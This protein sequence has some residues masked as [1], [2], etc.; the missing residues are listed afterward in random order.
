VGACYVEYYQQGNQLYLLNDAGT[1]W[2][3][4][5][6]TPGGSGVVAN[7]QCTLNASSSTVSTSG[8]NLTVNVSVTFVSSVGPSNV[9]LDAFDLGLQNS[10]W[11]DEGTWTP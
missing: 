7:S 1:A 6:L 10:G 5:G 8:N 2:L 11:V 9:Y 3:A 4:P